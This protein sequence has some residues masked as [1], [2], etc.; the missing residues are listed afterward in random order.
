MKAL[1]KF[2][3]GPGNLDILDVDEP[4]CG[5][6]Q[7]KVEIAFCGVCG[8]DLH[9]MHDTFRNYPPVILGHEFSGTVV[10]TGREVTGVSPGARVTVLGATAV[11]CGA[12]RYCREGRFIFCPDRR[13]MGHGVNG[14]FARYVVARPDQLYR[15]PDHFT[16][17]EAALSEPF[18]AAVQAVTEVTSVRLGETAL[19]SGPGPM[20]LL[21]LKLLAAEGVRTIVAG[22]A[23][24]DL[25]LEA[26][27]RFGAAAVIDTS[28]QDLAQAVRELTGGAGVDV[29][30]ECAGHPA[31]VRGCLDALRPMGR[32]TQVAICGRDIEFPIDRIF[33]KQLTV[34]G[35]VCYTARTW[36]RMIEIYRQGRVRL[37]DLVSV[38]LPIAEWR[39]AFDLCADRKALKV[40]MHP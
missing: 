32:Y 13:G 3:P 2:A 21:C 25:R 34:T 37:H 24:D 15:I 33:Y 22:A 27:A 16:L 12:C 10:E 36:E 5:P 28:R 23:G 39:A 29:A 31:S 40:L 8:T 30:L 35:S 26:A 18:A 19:I 1:V 9:V 11:T 38:K 7:V 6:R 14:A 4:I 17:E 20:G